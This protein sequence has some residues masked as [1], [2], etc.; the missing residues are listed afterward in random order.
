VHSAA[1]RY[2]SL[3]GTILCVCFRV[4]LEPDAGPRA[5]SFWVWQP[6]ASLQNGNDGTSQ[7]PGEPLCVYALF[8]DPGGIGDI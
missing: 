5:W 2:P 4:S 1:L 3:G 7:V 8:S 6:P